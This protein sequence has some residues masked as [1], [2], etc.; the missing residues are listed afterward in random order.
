[1]LTSSHFWWV[2]VPTPRRFLVAHLTICLLYHTNGPPGYVRSPWVAIVSHLSS[3]RRHA[4]VFVGLPTIFC[5]FCQRGVIFWNPFSCAWGTEPYVARYIQEN[6]MWYMCTFLTF[7]S[8]SSACTLV[9]TSRC[10]IFTWLD[11]IVLLPIPHF[12]LSQHQFHCIPLS[13]SPLSGCISASTRHLVPSWLSSYAMFSLYSFLFPSC[14]VN[15]NS[16]F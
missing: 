10:R 14:A 5:Q 9:S 15:P 1:M 12:L 6:A 16:P 4:V 3:S 11:L 7:N 13:Y 2:I 8:K